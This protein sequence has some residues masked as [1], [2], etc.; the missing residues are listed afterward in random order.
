MTRVSLSR[1]AA[2]AAAILLAA[3]ACR[4]D[5][6]GPERGALSPPPLRADR[7][8]KKRGRAPAP[9]ACIPR[10]AEKASEKF[11]P[12]GGI[13]RFGGSLLLIPPGALR[14][15]VRITAVTR[16]DASATVD[17]APEGLRFDRPAFLVLSASGCDTPEDG[18]PSVVYLG[19]E[20]EVLETIS[21]S[22]DRRWRE[23]IAPISHFSGYA[24][25]F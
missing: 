19:S 18:A 10:G 15:K 4:T 13:L 8:E 24:I 11:G 20:G 1:R 5:L 21:A 16:G 22:F 23:V 3:L 2:L 7:T 25:A 6:A 14:T 17:F 9:V 12:A